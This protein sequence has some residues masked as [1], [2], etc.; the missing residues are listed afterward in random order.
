MP[1]TQATVTLIGDEDPPVCEA[2][3]PRAAGNTKGAAPAGAAPF[4]VGVSG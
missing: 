2:T 4:G 1:R 3:S